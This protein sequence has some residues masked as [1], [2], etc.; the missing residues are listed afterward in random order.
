MLQI[1][2]PRDVA[3][4]L[5]DP[6]GSDSNHEGLYKWKSAVGRSEGRSGSK[7]WSASTCFWNGEGPE[8]EECGQ[9]GRWERLANG[10]SSVAREEL[11]TLLS[12]HWARP[13]WT[14]DLQ[15]CKL[16][17]LHCSC[18]F[19]YVIICRSSHRKGMQV[20]IKCTVWKKRKPSLKWSYFWPVRFFLLPFSL[21]SSTSG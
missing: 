15:N 18:T 6:C 8:G 12:F 17:D 11:T 20:V 9:P 4:V 21:W 1:S 13:T 3:R 5:D 19:Q 10:F 2:W 14:S 7:F 16:T